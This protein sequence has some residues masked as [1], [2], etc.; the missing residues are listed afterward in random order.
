MAK[1]HL[2]KEN[3]EIKNT[4]GQEAA[5][6]KEYAEIDKNPFFKGTAAVEDR[7]LMN[8]TFVCDNAAHEEAFLKYCSVNGVSGI[9]GHRSVGGFRASI[10]NAMPLESVEFLIGL[11][12][13]FKPE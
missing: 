4:P 5:K 10:Y 12:Q 3:A 7:S 8:V 6:P 1:D 2:K 11:M 13:N 9:A